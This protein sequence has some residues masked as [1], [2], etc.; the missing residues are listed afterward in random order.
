LKSTA[1]KK[2][3]YFKKLRAE[4]ADIREKRRKA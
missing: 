3:K 1:L 2:T 4:A